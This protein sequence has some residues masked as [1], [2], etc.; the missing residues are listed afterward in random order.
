MVDFFPTYRSMIR[1]VCHYVY[2]AAAP[3]SNWLQEISRLT[4]W[5]LVT[6][7]CVRELSFLV[8]VMALSYVQYQANAQ[9]MLTYLLSSEYLGKPKKWFWMIHLFQSNASEIISKIKTIMLRSQYVNIPHRNMLLFACN[10][11]F[12]I[13]ICLKTTL[14]IAFECNK[15]QW[16]EHSLFHPINF[17]LFL[18]MT[19]QSRLRQYNAPPHAD[20]VP[21]RCLVVVR[22]GRAA[23][24][25]RDRSGVP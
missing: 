15:W 3:H 5:G 23:R 13:E 19:S 16:H 11:P 6:N 8:Q 2:F 25:C 20:C 9:P 1:C 7:I 22:G 12:F 21:R 17:P 10:K 4:H 14:F 18:C 24:L